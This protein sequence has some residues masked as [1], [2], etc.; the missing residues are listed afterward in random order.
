[1]ATG[2]SSSFDQALR[3]VRDVEGWMTDAQ[4]RR[5]WDRAEAV[6]PDGRIVEIG[7]F[8]GRSAIVIAKAAA[9]GVE[10][11]AIDPHGGN[12]RGPQEIKAD[13]V[14]GEA[15]H[16]RFHAN[17]QAAG[18]N[19]RIRHVRMPSQDV[20]RE[21]AD[22]IEMLYIDGAHRYGPAR[23]DIRDWGERV[24]IGG[25]MLIHDSFSSIGVTFAIFSQLLFSNQL[26]YVGRSGSLAEYRRERVGFRARLAS[27]GHQLAQVPWFV[28]N[29]II[30]V[31]LV[32]HLRPLT[33]LFGH[34][35]GNWPY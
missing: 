30:K 11:I 2:T 31:L 4:A 35:T 18:V 27:A 24:E 8:R 21:V 23:D 32:L 10:V 15:D 17:L 14:T 34:T 13:A 12:D 1:V 6:G 19:E 28:R 25:T 9:P 33:R 16:E 22:P 5:L 7:S 26:R 20:G 3:A 29:V